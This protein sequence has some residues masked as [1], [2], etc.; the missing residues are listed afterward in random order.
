MRT[1]ENH[2]T[3]VKCAFQVRSRTEILP[4]SMAQKFPW[5][6]AQRYRSVPAEHISMT[7]VAA[8]AGPPDVLDV[9]DRYD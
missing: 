7:S 3:P 9:D 2:R 1:H 6:W 8:S 4:C 5:L